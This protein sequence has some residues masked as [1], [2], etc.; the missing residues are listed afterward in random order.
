MR[1]RLL[2]LNESRQMLRIPMRGYETVKEAI[3][4]VISACYESP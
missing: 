3:K 1:L 2:Q 4:D